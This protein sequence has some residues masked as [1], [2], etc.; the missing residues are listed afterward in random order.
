MVGAACALYAAR[1][2]LDV[3]VVDRGPVAGGT[4]G[5][6]EGNV[7]VSDKE[8]GPELALALLSQRLW[9]ELTGREP[10]LTDEVVEI[11]R[12]EWA[13]SS[14]RAER[15]LAY[16]ITPFAEGVVRTVAWLRATGALRP[17]SA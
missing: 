9:A 5:A 17:G 6:G 12:H 4:T 14:A 10:E 3:V 13:Y 8:P 16:R 1:T 11:Y 15:D 2:G 7:L